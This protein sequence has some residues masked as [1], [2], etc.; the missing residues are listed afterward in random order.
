MH[1]FSQHGEYGLV[2]MQRIADDFFVVRE[3]QHV[4]SVRKYASLDT[5]LL[6]E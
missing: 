4:I 1:R 5:L 6:E 3:A 2:S